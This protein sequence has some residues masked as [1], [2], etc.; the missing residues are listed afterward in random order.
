M[1]PE[2]A[3]RMHASAELE[4]PALIV[5][6]VEDASRMGARCIYYLVK[7]LGCRE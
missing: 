1:T 5:G 6:W 3:F 7:K 4:S 2:P